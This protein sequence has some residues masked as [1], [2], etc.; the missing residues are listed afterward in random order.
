MDKAYILNQ[1]E[2]LSVQQ[3]FEAIIQGIITL[4][5]LRDT[6]NL[7]ASKRK[8]ILILIKQQD[9]EEE[10]FWENA[11]HTELGCRNYL[12]KFP[13]GKFVFEAKNTINLNEHQ[14]EK[15]ERDRKDIIE[16]LKA[17]P[18]AHGT[19]KIKTLLNDK[20][21]TKDDLLVAGIP[22]KI[23]NFLDKEII[24]KEPKLGET[25]E[26]IPEGF[27]EV[28]F[29]GI[30]G[31]GKTCALGAV[32]RAA[33]NKGYLEIAWGDGSDYSYQLK[34]IFL[35][36][37][38]ILPD[39]TPVETTQYL[40]FTLK[41]PDE[42]FARSVSL[43]ELSGEIFECF[44]Y[45]NNNKP[46]KSPHH[47]ATFNSLTNFL[48]GSNRKIHFFFIDYIDK[49]TTDDKG[50]CQ[51]DYLGATA[52]FFDNKQNNF[53][54]KT[55]DAI[56]IVLTK[57]DLMSCEK[58]DRI[59]KLKSYLQSNNFNAF[60]NSLRSKC[61]KHHINGRRILGTPFSLGKVY[62]NVLC[63]F[64]P[65]AAENILDILMRRIKPKKESILDVLNK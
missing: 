16:E 8:Q 31:S 28:Y 32:L 1:V 14:K 50:Y 37:I 38:S 18:N 49:N 42:K 19:Y 63:D 51:S 33:E 21:I 20:V 34:N 43:I 58:D 4:E 5:E 3:L 60:I 27:T 36:P 54:G 59:Q 46:L 30:P 47:E 24:R 12:T 10:D 39:R 15:I 23:I 48:N 44:I 7:D 2:S 41:T 64:D 65:E 25:P 29:W 56:Y 61:K 17:N 6:G 40:P 22:L 57:S 55:T 62:F 45:K 26:S 11:K 35:N 52:T 53:F 9:K 13:A